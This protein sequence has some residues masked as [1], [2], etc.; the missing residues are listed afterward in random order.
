MKFCNR[1]GRELEDEVMVC[2]HCGGASKATKPSYGSGS[3]INSSTASLLINLFF[4]AIFLTGVILLVVFG[5]KEIDFNTHYDLSGYSSKGVDLIRSLTGNDANIPCL[6][7]GGVLVGI[8]VFG[9][10]SYSICR[11]GR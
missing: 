5:I 6:I 3:R 7:V 10:I 11:E 8:A 1:C 9:G 2:P 4:V